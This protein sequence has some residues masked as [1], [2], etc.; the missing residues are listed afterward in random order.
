MAD[1]ILNEAKQR[2]SSI[3]LE[4]G[5]LLLLGKVPENRSYDSMPLCDC[6]L[7]VSLCSVYYLYYDSVT[8]IFFLK[9]ESCLNPCFM[10]KQ[11]EL[12]RHFLSSQQ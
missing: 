1:V 4:A 8:L 11:T 6:S 3:G 10:V 9:D 2:S 7:T 5:R 12:R